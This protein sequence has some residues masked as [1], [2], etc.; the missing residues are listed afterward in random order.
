MEWLEAEA[1]ET[2][3]L[4]ARVR[5]TT[6][7]GLLD[8]ESQRFG[9]LSYAAADGERPTRFSVHFE[10]RRLDGFI[11]PIDQRYVFDGRWLLDLDGQDRVATR[12]ELVPEGETLE[13]GLGGGP[14]VIPLNLKK[15]EVLARFEAELVG[16]GDDDPAASTD[17]GSVHLRLT[18]RL[19]VEADA[20]AFD[21]W[22]D[23][24]DG[25]PLRAASREEDGDT[26]IVDL[27]R[28][29]ANAE[30]KDAAFDTTLP[31]DAGWETQVVPLD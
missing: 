12:R 4:A 1:G 10:R 17:A 20:E 19:G 5:L 24:A 14:F 7:V 22:F 11:E 25:L 26:N 13:L 16:A 28:A 31:R 21:L 3:T 18:P 27:F 6:V 15:D 29:E 8:E 30:L 2:R 23:R 9:T